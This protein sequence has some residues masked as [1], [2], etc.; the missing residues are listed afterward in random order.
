[1]ASGAMLQRLAQEF[2]AKG[3]LV[4]GELDV[5]GGRQRGFHFCQR[6]VREALGLQGGDVDAGRIGERAVADGIGLDLGDIAFAVA[7]R[8]QRH[9]TAWLMIFQ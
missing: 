7:E 9:G 5:E 1:M 6:F 2:L 3:P 4:E 8:A